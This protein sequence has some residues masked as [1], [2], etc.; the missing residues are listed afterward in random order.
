MTTF[1]D[2]SQEYYGISRIDDEDHRAHAWRVSLRR[3]G[4]MHVKNF[5]DK[6]H[7]G[8]DQAQIAAFAFRDG[9]IASHQPITRREICTSK[10][11]NN[12][13][14]I[15]GVCSYAKRYTLRDGT[16]RENWYWEGNWPNQQGE[17]VSES[18]SVKTYGNELARSMAIRARQRGLEAL[19]GYFWASERGAPNDQPSIVDRPKMSA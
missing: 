19:E 2:P 11:S 18:F 13:S 7:G 1:A 15:T 17:A 4:Q 8:K 14:G 10:R 16:L 9:I 3:R 6:K 12:K 5:T